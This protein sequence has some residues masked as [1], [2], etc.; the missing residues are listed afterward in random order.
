M[1]KFIK[2]TES[3][4]YQV[5]K[6]ELFIT[7]LQLLASLLIV[8]GSFALLFE[9][10]YFTDFSVKIYLGRLVA[11]LIGFLILISTNFRFGKE[12]PILLI[13][14]LL[15]TII[16]SFVSIILL[17]PES[18]FINS[19]L[20][21]LIIFTSALFL[22]WD[23]KNQIIVAIYYNLL[24]AASILLNNQSI[25]F[26]PS[27]FSAFIFVVFIS[28]LSIAATAINLKLR[29]EVIKKTIEA[30]N[31]LD[32]ASEGIFKI[33]LNGDLIFV[34]PAF[35]TMLKLEFIKQVTSNINFNQLF[36]NI[37]DYNNF[38]NEV[39][40]IGII[41]DKE[42]AFLDLLKG[43]VFVLLN[44]RTV[45]GN[46]KSIVAVEGSIL[47]ITH[48]VIAQKKIKE[49]NIEL[50]KLNQNKDKFFSI[51]AHDLISPFTSLIGFSEIMYNEADDLS[52]EEVKEF[53][54]NIFG[55]A[56]KA[57]NLLENLLSWSSLQSNRI[58]FSPRVFPIYSVVE[59]VL[60]LNKGNANSKGIKLTNN[61]TQ[62]LEIYADFNMINAIL[63]NLVSNSVKFT[64]SG[65][66]ISVGVAEIKDFF[67][68]YVQDTGVGI[69]EENM[70]KL[71]NVGVHFSET[72]TNKEKGTGLGLVLCA[73]F[74]AKHN[75]SISVES[76]LGKGS[77]FIFTISKTLE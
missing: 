42:Y 21:S 23:V 29:A 49:Y 59:D 30:K 24:F 34:N 66:E 6:N 25:Y 60:L 50:E 52:R 16:S 46:N 4:I 10:K 63:R 19:Q 73:E 37:E 75:G 26:L 39:K 65:G 36:S 3:N 11:T 33:S 69:L 64:N 48:R 14:V 22:S 53:S 71:F 27:F 51:V 32:N 35:I 20:L 40:E 77:K 47:D 44:A 56:T 38:I 9:V 55:V 1:E 72:G 13:H 8:A 43:E 41:R 57:H 61:V 70:K 45:I 76:E 28:L 2:S 31:Y 12:H 74:I 68:F 54:G 5:V 67:E 17:I 15:L 7:P 18:I 62:Q 58:M